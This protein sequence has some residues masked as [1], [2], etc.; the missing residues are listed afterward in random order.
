[1]GESADPASW[2]TTQIG[3]NLYQALKQIL[4][5]KH[6]AKYIWIDALCI[7]QKDM[8]ERA[9]QVSIMTEIY[10]RCERTI[11]WLGAGG[12]IPRDLTEFWLLH[13]QVVEPLSKH[14]QEHGV[15]SLSEGWNEETFHEKL[16][17]IARHCDWE[18]YARFYR[19]RTFFSRSWMYQELSFAKAMTV[20]I[21]HHQMNFDEMAL[22]A[23]FLRMSGLGLSLCAK[24][25]G[26]D[27]EH[28]GLLKPRTRNQ[29]PEAV[30][31]LDQSRYPG[32]QID[33]FHQ[34]RRQ[35]HGIGTRAWLE[36]IAKELCMDDL[37]M[38]A[39]TF[40]AYVLDEVRIAQAGDLHDKVYA[41]YGFLKKAL[42]PLGIAPRFQPRY[43]MSV[44]ELYQD[45]A[46]ILLKTTPE[47][48][49]LCFKEPPSNTNLT[50]LPSW[51]PDWNARG[52]VSLAGT[53]HFSRY[54]ASPLSGNRAPPLESLYTLGQLDGV[55]TLTLNES[56]TIGRITHVMSEPQEI[57]A[58]ADEDEDATVIM[59]LK[60]MA[61]HTVWFELL[62]ALA[63][64][65]GQ[66]SEGEDWSGNR[67]DLFIDT[68][69]A[70]H[71]EG[72]QGW[73]PVPHDHFK[74]YITNFL[75]WFGAY[76]ELLVDGGPEDK[77]QARVC[78]NLLLVFYSDARLH[79]DLLPSEKEVYE[80]RILRTRCMGPYQPSKEDHERVLEEDRKV[81][82]FIQA[83]ERH[84]LNRNLFVTDTA[85]LRLGSKDC[86]EGD[87]VVL[88]N[89]ARVL[90]VVRRRDDLET[91][92]FIGEAYVSGAM[93]GELMPTA[94]EHRWRKIALV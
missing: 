8:E 91:Y 87:E 11:V 42:Q 45:I 80:A 15:D 40:F 39:Y 61:L 90:F 94:K 28:T 17:I 82:S 86:R 22:L 14:V 79:P 2:S 33:K 51:C 69:L 60:L 48:R 65:T 13:V 9:A 81:D 10:S 77:E 16:G 47:F 44:E 26:C 83:M 53:D 67:W 6:D 76:I 68:L 49:V 21:A 89:G 35:V 1:M 43:F 4:K 73:K 37:E 70:G 7:N 50:T 56:Y 38:A 52:H 19:D 55:S 46:E 54:N 29:L 72:Q 78:F 25:V 58:D 88:L 75:G 23:R 71:V 30:D 93:H 32:S 62:I 5:M 84:M 20:L 27:E 12:I 64:A 74:A 18:G 24:N 59:T 36:N 41:A 66:G 3:A 57:D 63:D 92:T 34:L 85:L 31:E